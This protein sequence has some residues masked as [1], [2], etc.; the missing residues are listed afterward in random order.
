MLRILVVDDAELMVGLRGSFL[1]RAQCTVLPARSPANLVRLARDKRPDAI[2]LSEAMPEGS[3]KEALEQVERDSALADVP[4]IWIGEPNATPPNESVVALERP[5]ARGSLP[6]ALQALLDVPTRM[7]PRRAARISVGYFSEESDGVGYVGD[8]SVGGMFL[9][10]RGVLAR[11]AALQLI[12][13]LPIEGRPRIRADGRVVYR[14]PSDATQVAGLG[15]RFHRL[16]TRDRESIRAYVGG[17][18]PERR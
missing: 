14:I 16:G 18:P 6:T 2:V 15:V 9:R 12:F 8:L 11:G 17:S 13:N 5:L 4:L 1:G 7:Q 10:T 3:G